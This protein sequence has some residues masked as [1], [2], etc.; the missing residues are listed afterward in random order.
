MNMKTPICEE[1]L[2]T[3]RLTAFWLEFMTKQSDHQTSGSEELDEELKLRLSAAAAVLFRWRV[4]V[5]QRA[6][7]IEIKD[8]QDWEEDEY[9]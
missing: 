8:I 1:L 7:L 2:T 3:A 6:G 9:D 4:I 5:G